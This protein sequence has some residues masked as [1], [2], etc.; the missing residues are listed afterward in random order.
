MASVAIDF[1]TPP[2]TTTVDSEELAHGDL[3][4]D[5]RYYAGPH[6]RALS[7]VRDSDLPVTTIGGEGGLADVWMPAR[8]KRIYAAD[9]KHG[10]PFLRAHSVFF[11]SPK[12][13]RYLSTVLTKDGSKTSVERGW[14][15]LARSGTVG[16]VAY[17]TSMLTGFA[18]TDDLLRVVPKSEDDGL[19]LYAYLLSSTGK[20]LIT[21][22]EHG[23][24]VPHI[25]EE[26]AARVPV[27][28][29]GDGSRRS[30]V[31]T[32]RSAA[33]MREKASARLR[34]AQE[35]FL[36]ISRIPQESEFSPEYLDEEVRAW[37]A[38]SDQL[39]LRLDSEFYSLDHAEAKK[40]AARSE[41]S[42]RLEAIAELRLPGRY[43][44]YYV[45]P[46]FGVPI[47]GGR[48][49][50]QWRPIGVKRIADRSFKNP[51]E[52][53]LSAGMTV[54]PADGRVSEKIGEPTYVTSSWEGWKGSNHLMRAIPKTGVGAGILFLALQA[55]TTQIQIRAAA[56][57]SVVDALV[58]QLV[59]EAVV[60]FPRG[61]EAAHLD[62]TVVQAFEDL[63]GALQLEDRAVRKFEEAL[64]DG[65]RSPA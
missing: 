37:T 36:V 14:V 51:G 29:L 61:S 19:Y 46:P 5:A 4:L 38:G 54:F 1:V 44:R 59:G 43:K 25:S 48:H 30:I 15:L 34:E 23:S 50:H 40:L 33:E 49:I 64:D 58:P 47:L 8:F 20:L 28:I 35:R 17:A 65:Y 56:T 55:Y 12:S 26:Q 32:M 21:H 13:E 22:D 45:E 41:S 42:V 63:A 24:A 11:R 27:P 18:L 7:M 39:R 3:R 16:A 6:R 9:E 52:Y 10:I 57:G 53:E 31:Q 60:P 2:Q 62:R